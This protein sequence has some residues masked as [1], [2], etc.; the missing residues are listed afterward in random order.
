[1]GKPTG[2]MEFEREA[3]P[4]RDPLERLNDYDE[5][6]ST[7]EEGHLQTQGARAHVGG[8]A[9]DH[10]PVA[11]RGCA[12]DRARVM[13]EEGDLAAGAI[14]VS[15]VGARAR[16]VS[17]AR[18]EANAA[19]IDPA[20]DLADE[21]EEGV[22]LVAD[23][24]V[25]QALVRR[26]MAVASSMAKGAGVTTRGTVGLSDVAGRGPSE[27]VPQSHPQTLLRGLG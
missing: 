1:M 19:A 10:P 16:S 20:E 25:I 13:D 9:L 12:G 17:Q 27:C 24:V 26:H 3:V 4:Y 8:Q 2:F 14:E 7:P 11:N 5:I 15:C 21:Q 6:N 18:E 22:A 23:A